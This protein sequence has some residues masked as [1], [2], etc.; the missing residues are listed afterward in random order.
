VGEISLFIF[1]SAGH[2]TECLEAVQQIVEDVKHKVPI[3][4]KEIMEDGSVRW[5]E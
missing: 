3:W 2:R 1:A 5:V 4:K